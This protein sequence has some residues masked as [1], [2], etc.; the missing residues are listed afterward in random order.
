LETVQTETVTSKH[1]YEIMQRLSHCH[2]VF[3]CRE[4]NFIYLKPFKISCMGNYG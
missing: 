4:C 1:Q 2:N 3:V